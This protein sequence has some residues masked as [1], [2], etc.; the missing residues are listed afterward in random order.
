LR[1]GVVG[2]ATIVVVAVRDPATDVAPVSGYGCAW[3][4]DG[5]VVY[6]VGRDPRERSVGVWRVPAE[7]GSARLVVRFDDPS[8]PWHLYGFRVHG[9]RFYFTVG[10]EQSDI[11]MTEVVGS[12]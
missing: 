3:S 1:L 8:R 2:L 10:D 9:S 11:W 7:G 12:R 5:R 6:F 4:A